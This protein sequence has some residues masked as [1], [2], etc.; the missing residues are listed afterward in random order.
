[1]SKTPERFKSNVIT[2]NISMNSS[3]Y[4]YDLPPSLVET[5]C[6]IIDSGSDSLGWRGLAARIVPSLLEF[7][8]A[9]R[10]EANGKSPTWELLWSWSQQNKTV[11]DLQRVLEDMGQFRALKLFD[12]VDAGYSFNRPP[13]DTPPLSDAPKS[14]TTGLEPNKNNDIHP[15]HVSI[16]GTEHRNVITYS[17]VIEGTRDFHPDM[18]ILEAKFSDVYKGLK[19][20]EAFIVKL[21]KQVKNASW[22]KLWEFFRREMEVHNLC[23]D[24][25]ILELLGC[26]SDGDRY[27]LV[28]PY[29][30]NGS[31][32]HRL[33]DPSA[34]SPLSWQER[35]AII[36]GIAKALHH[37]HNKQPCS[38]VFGNISS[39]NIFLDESLQ[40]KLF[41]FGTARLRPHPVNHSCTITLDTSCHDNLGYLPQEYIRDGKLSNSLDVY[42]FGM[43]T[44]EIITGRKVI[45]E[46]PKNTLLRDLLSVEVEESGSVDSCLRFLDQGA[47]VWPLSI[48][49]SL[50]RL[51]L[52][53]TATR[54]RA[55]PNMEAVLHVLS[56]LL[57]LP[58]CPPNDLPHSLVERIPP[59]ATLDTKP[60]LPPQ[61]D[62]PSSDPFSEA[63][64]MGPCECSQSEVTYLSSNAEAQLS[65]LSSQLQLE[66]A[67]AQSLPS[68]T[69]SLDLYGSWPVQCSCPA[70]LN[71]QA[72]DDCRANGFTPYPADISQGDISL[73]S[74]MIVENLAKERLRNKLDLYNRSLINTEEL[75]SI[76]HR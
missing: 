59:C 39:V 52:D 47:G 1:M 35:L 9:E 7:R 42:G 5:L 73:N 29:L 41:D 2:F 43:V 55:R 6:K 8:R 17:D 54:P 22:N 24:P 68:E 72:C 34:A 57:P 28:Y 31:L 12:S 46:A 3:T 63:A 15:S 71:G 64:K 76:T 19:G 23:Q 21:F 38:V 18:R 61:D 32:Y 27:C 37:L 45:E 49:L 13:T 33:H 20:N 74:E 30:Q 11:A 66:E 10:L 51:A 69:E 60:S 65:N 75:L 58:S 67:A 36:K 44:M 25:N 14:L 56:Q 70:E 40:P 4:F 62:E 48:S 50:L 26:F 53:C 16:K